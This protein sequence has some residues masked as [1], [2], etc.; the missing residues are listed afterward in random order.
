M[1][2]AVSSV[3]LLLAAVVPILALDIRDNLRYFEVLR[4]ADFS[5]N[6][7][8]RGAD[9]TSSHRFNKIREIGFKALGK[10]FRLVLSPKKGLLHPKFKAVEVDV[11]D[12]GV[13]RERRVVID[14]ENFYEGR[15]FGEMHSRAAVFMEVGFMMA[16]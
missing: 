12:D 7:V 13:H 8:K 16:L 1:M 3:L 5:H 6:I 10:D 4:D 2:R 15:V 14:P 9:P 11:D